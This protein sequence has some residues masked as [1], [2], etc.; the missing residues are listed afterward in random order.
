[1]DL[2]G[3]YKPTGM[4]RT[5]PNLLTQE[6]VLGLEWSRWYR[7]I[8]P[9]HNVT[10]AF[11][12]LIAGPMDYTPG[13][14][15]NATRREFRARRRKPMVLGTRCHQLAMYVVYES[16]L[17]MLCDSPAA[18]RGQA[19]F[20]FLKRVPTVWDETKVID[21]KVADYIVIARRSGREWYLGGMTDWTP[22]ELVIPLEFLGEGQYIAEIYADAEDADRNPQAVEIRRE[23]VE[24]GGRM[25]VRLASGG[26]LAVI[27]TPLP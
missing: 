4:S 14:F 13:G 6:A 27:F 16:T 5:Y 17:Q 8:D 26:G 18:Y 21:G 11:T 9:E 10:L 24:A 20:E 2:H 25:R 1:L 12:R 19:G 3:S 23:V 7:G 15:R 22:R